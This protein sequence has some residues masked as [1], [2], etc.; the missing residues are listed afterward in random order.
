[1]TAVVPVASPPAP[2]PV[3]AALAAALLGA[4]AASPPAPKPVTVVLAALPPASQPMVAVD[5][6]V[7]DAVAWVHMPAAGSSLRRLEHSAL[8]AILMRV[9][10]EARRN[11]AAGNAESR[12][13]VTWRQGS[14]GAIDRAVAVG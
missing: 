9:L 6:A 12:L 14:A 3:A 8:G 7:D 4:L 11:A 5:D 10:P 13:V 1:M 2:K